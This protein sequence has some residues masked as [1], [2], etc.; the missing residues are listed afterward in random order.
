M[1]G[2][3]M[4]SYPADDVDRLLRLLYEISLH[5]R[6]TLEEG[7]AAAAVAGQDPAPD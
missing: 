6:A 3:K 5:L 4:R 2:E 7:S 1:L